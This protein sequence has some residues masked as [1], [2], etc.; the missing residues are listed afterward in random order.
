LTHRFLKWL[1]AGGTL[2]IL[3]AFVAGSAFAGSATAKPDVTAEFT[4]IGSVAPE[5]LTN[6]RTIHGPDE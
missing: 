6:A 5:F 3:T 2:A 1:V 4:T